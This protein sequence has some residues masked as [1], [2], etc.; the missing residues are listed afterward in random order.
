MNLNV[1]N[2]YLTVVQSQSTKT[3]R[4]TIH[5]SDPK[6]LGYSASLNLT[7]NETARLVALL[8]YARH[9]LENRLS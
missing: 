1:E 5:D 8:Q 7:A 9:D 4:L 2:G 6:G 3:I